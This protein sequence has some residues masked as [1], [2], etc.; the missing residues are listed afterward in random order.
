MMSREHSSEPSFVHL[1]VD[2]ERV[3]ATAM[4]RQHLKRAPEPRADLDG[5]LGSLVLYKLHDL[6]LLRWAHLPIERGV[7][8]EKLSEQRLSQEPLAFDFAIPGGKAHLLTIS[9]SCEYRLARSVAP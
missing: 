6:H 9:V 8:L 2:I 5:G 1:G 7:R 4:P 3:N